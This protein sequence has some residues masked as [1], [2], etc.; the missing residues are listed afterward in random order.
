MR[1]TLSRRAPLLVSVAVAAPLL[2]AGCGSSGDNASNTTTTTG[3]SGGVTG[4]IT[5]FAAASL[6]GTFTTLGKQFEAAHPGTKVTFNFGP[7]SGLATSIN[8]GAPADV[9]ASAST[10]N[11]DQVVSAGNAAD[12]KTFAT[13]SMEIAV[14]PKNPA[15]VTSVEDLA[16]S[17]VKVAVCQSEVPCGVV[18]AK[19]FSNAGIKVKP[20]TEEADVKS[21]LTKVVNDEVDAGVVYVT[22]VK[23]AG[24]TVKGVVI[25]EKDNATT[26]YPIA[27]VKASKNGTTA[28]AFMAYVLSADGLA[29]LQKAGFAKP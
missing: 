29:V 1:S 8:Q 28:D 16:K 11:M 26:T 14:P 20:V 18:A 3:G 7:S 6:T 5:V 17:S 27:T 13:N 21:V 24:D 2:L 22:D 4:D 23:A 9:F 12:P 15:N 25:P 10:T 19:V